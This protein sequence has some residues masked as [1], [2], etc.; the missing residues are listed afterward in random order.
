M[1]DDAPINDSNHFLA[2]KRLA[3]E[4]R[5]FVLVQ[6]IAFCVF[7]LSLF[8]LTPDTLPNSPEWD[9]IYSL[10]TVCVAVGQIAFLGA[11]FLGCYKLIGTPF[12]PFSVRL[13]AWS[14]LV[15]PFF[16][17]F[18]FILTFH[19]LKTSILAS[20]L[21]DFIFPLYCIIPQYFIVRW[22]AKETKNDTIQAV[23]DG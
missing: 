15:A 14:V 3:R 20:V 13:Y 10:C 7:W 4:L 8:L 19:F 1:S 16:R 18:V 11:A 22:L 17:P 6:V 23:E 12:L 9:G 2:K 21:C 5:I